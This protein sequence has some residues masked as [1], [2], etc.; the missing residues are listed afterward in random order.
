MDLIRLLELFFFFPMKTFTFASKEMWS[1][2]GILC[3]N[4]TYTNA[5]LRK[6]T[7]ERSSP[8]VSSYPLVLWSVGRTPSTPAACSGLGQMKA[9]FLPE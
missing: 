1:F 8:A 4:T 3:M 5:K 7:T 2:K 6:K 9:V